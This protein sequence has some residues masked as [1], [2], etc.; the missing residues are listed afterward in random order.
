MDDEQQTGSGSRWESGAEHPDDET[1]ELAAHDPA[2]QPVSTG[3]T[4]RSAW[5]RSRGA[6]V[7][8]GV[9]LATVVGLGGFALGHV[10]A[11]GDGDHRHGPG[12]HRFDD[13]RGREGRRPDPHMRPDGRQGGP[14]QAPN[15]APSPTPSAGGGS[16]S[17]DD[18]SS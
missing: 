1:T 10:T 3:T 12:F 11:D 13:D 5:M 7:G 18:S 6:V 9:G 15:V 17:E 16:S 14:K 8:A 4:E 2:Q